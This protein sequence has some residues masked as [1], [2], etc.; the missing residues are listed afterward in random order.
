MDLGH[1]ITAQPFSTLTIGSE[2]HPVS[3]L[4]PLCRYHPLWPRVSIWLSTGVQYPLRPLPEKDRKL[5]LQANLD[6]G[7]HQSATYN[8][9]RLTEMLKDEISHGWQLILSCE[10]AL[11]IPNAVLAPLSLVEQD[12]INEFGEIFPKWRL[13]HDQSFNII[14]GTSRS[15]NDCLITDDLTTCRYGKAL[16]RHI[17]FVIGL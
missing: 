15:V 4:E 2:F 3:V 16:N 1:A 14:K 8:K 12:T 9:Q 6:R 13:I 10:A 7:N 17:H 11:Q 5:D